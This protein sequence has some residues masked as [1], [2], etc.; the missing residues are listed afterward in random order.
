M[1]GVR[2]VMQSE[3]ILAL[4]NVPIE[5][6]FKLSKER[7]IFEIRPEA[8]VLER[9]FFDQVMAPT[10]L[11]IKFDANF[12]RQLYKDLADAEAAG[13]IADLHQ[14]YLQFGYFENRMPFP[15]EV[16][17]S[18]YA[19]EY[20]DVAA[21]IL[22]NRVASAQ[23]HFEAVGFAEGRLPRRGWAFADLLQA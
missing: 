22:E 4:A 12:Y 6:F 23:A 13:H 5:P 19:R 11:R 9:T 15:V 1:S 14:H 16:D 20:P 17:G 3:A 18:F 21:A 8:V 7:K 10:L 2:K